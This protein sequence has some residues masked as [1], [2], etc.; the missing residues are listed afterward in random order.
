MYWALNRKKS[1]LVAG[2]RELPVQWGTG[3]QGKLRGVLLRARCMEMT[4]K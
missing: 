3:R 1:E 2:L 4:W